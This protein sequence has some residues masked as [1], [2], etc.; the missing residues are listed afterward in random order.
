MQKKNTSIAFVKRKLSQ[1]QYKDVGVTSF[2]S[3]ILYVVMNC[4]KI[5]LTHKL[6]STKWKY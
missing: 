4:S 2:G 5:L 3:F 6:L 1:D